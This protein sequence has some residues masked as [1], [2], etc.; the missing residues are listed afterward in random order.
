MIASRDHV[1]S[2]V[3]HFAL[4]DA[5]DDL[6]ADDGVVPGRPAPVTLPRSFIA[7]LID[8]CH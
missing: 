5:V 2:G 8:L 3:R 7:V 1:F 4:H 6:L